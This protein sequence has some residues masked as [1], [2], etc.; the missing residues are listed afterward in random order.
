MLDLLRKK[1]T[2]KIVSFADAGLAVLEA[3]G[4]RINGRSA[5]ELREMIAR[6]RAQQP[7]Q[8]KA[9]D[10]PTQGNRN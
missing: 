4:A 6:R 7:A 3:R 9:G 8:P 10:P 1:L 5:T 2:E